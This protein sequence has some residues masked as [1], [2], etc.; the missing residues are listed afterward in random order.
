MHQGRPPTHGVRRATFEVD[1]KRWELWTVFKPHLPASDSIEYLKLFA[2][3][4]A[5]KANYWLAWNHERERWE[6]S[7]GDIATLQD[8]EPELAARVLAAVLEL[9]DLLGP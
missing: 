8:R 7:R 5:P 4:R 3:G 1:G 9:G 6:Y 2:V